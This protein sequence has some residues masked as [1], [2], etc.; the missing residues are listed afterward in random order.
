MV[1]ILGWVWMAAREPVFSV[2][3]GAAPRYVFSGR[4]FTEPFNTIHAGFAMD[5]PTI[6]KWLFWFTVMAL[7]SLPYV[8]LLG[9]LANRKAKTGRVA[10]A[11][12]VSVLGVFLLCILSGPVCLLIQYVCSM[13][14]TPRRICG[15]VYG[16]ASGLLVIGFVAWSLRNPARK[17]AEDRQ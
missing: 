10:F 3:S 9:W 6:G 4:L 5:Q 8:A 15:L 7:S 13:G 17:D 12:G 16:F 1:P 11:F 2:F 14:F